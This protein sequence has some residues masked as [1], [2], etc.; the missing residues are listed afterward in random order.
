MNQKFLYDAKFLHKFL[1]FHSQSVNCVSLFDFIEEEKK[2][3]KNNYI[4]E[5]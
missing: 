4:P 5:F 1:S 3:S 2:I